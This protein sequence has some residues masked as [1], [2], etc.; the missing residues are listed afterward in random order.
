MLH[1]YRR[2]SSRKIFEATSR[3]KGESKVETTEE[4]LARQEQR[5]CTSCMSLVDEQIRGL[6]CRAIHMV[7]AIFFQRPGE[8]A[9][10]PMF[11]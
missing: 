3:E 11:I 2:N 7:D 6:V 1:R 9:N 5:L 10:Q 8:T 4:I